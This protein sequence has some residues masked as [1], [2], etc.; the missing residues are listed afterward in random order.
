LDGNFGLRIDYGGYA[1]FHSDLDEYDV[2]DQSMTVEP[3]W[4]IDPFVCSLPIRYTYAMQDG[5]SDYHRVSISP[6]A[7]VKIPN[8]NNAVEVYGIFSKSYDVDQFND[9]DED[10]Y[11]RGGGIEYIFFS[12]NRTYFRLKGDYQYIYY[13]AKVAAYE[14][15]LNTSEK[16]HDSIIS[17]TAEHN[18]QVNSYLDIFVN[19]THIIAKSNVSFYDYDRNIIEAGVSLDF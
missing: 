7:T 1:D 19:F 2:I 9:Y 12:E 17:L 16:R 13:D 18:I 10:S 14:N 3:Q 4:R 11:S 5:E 8:V 15:T 6:T